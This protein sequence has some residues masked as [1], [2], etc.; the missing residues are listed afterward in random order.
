[1]KRIP[2]ACLFLVLTASVTNL[3]AQ[4][5][6]PISRQGLVNAVKLFFDAVKADDFDKIKSNYAADYTFTGPNGKVTDAEG[7]LRVLKAQGGNNFVSAS[8]LVYRLYG[9]A[10]VVTGVATTKTAGGGTEQARFIQVW[11]MQGGNLR[12]VASQVTRIE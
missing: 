12:L 7:R 9:D 4:A 8:E 3:M 10:A 11:T 5:K 1:M 2:F 6:K